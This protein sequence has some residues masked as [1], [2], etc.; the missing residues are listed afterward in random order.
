MGWKGLKA[1]GFEKEAARMAY[2]W[3]YMINHSLSVLFIGESPSS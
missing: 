1:Y 2:R 3:I